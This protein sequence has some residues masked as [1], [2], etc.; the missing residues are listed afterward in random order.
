MNKIA[1]G[2]P[3]MEKGIWDISQVPGG[4]AL[5]GGW[6]DRARRKGLHLVPREPT[7]CEEDRQG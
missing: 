7:A 5:V 6:L 4:R 1:S 3:R 2:K